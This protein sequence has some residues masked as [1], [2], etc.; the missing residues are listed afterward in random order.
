VPKQRECGELKNKSKMGKTIRRKREIE[1]PKGESKNA[2]KRERDW[3]RR[4]IEPKNARKRE[5]DWERRL[6]EPD[7][8]KRD[9]KGER[10]K[11]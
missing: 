5:R 9:F 6:I 1:K 3:E 8:W 7:Y 10:D 11:K 4:L 2:R